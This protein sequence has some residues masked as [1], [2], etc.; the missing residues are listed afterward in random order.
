VAITRAVIPAAGKGTRLYPASRA[1]AKEML[2]LGTKPVVQHVV[3]E[4]V[5]AGIT[6]IVIVTGRKKQAIEDH[7]DADQRWLELANGEDAE[8][9]PWERG[10]KLFYTRQ[11][12]PLGLGDAISKAQPFCEDK[13]FAVA[14]GDA[15]I[16]KKTQGP[17]VVQRLVDAFES[18]GA[19]A[20]VATYQVELEATSRYGILAPAEN[21]PCEGEPFLLAD[22]VEKPGPHTAPSCW[23]VSARYV[24]SPEIF[25]ALE[26]CRDS[27]KPGEELQLTSAL[28]ELIRRGRSVYGV[29]LASDE[30]RLDVGDFVSYGRAFARMLAMHPKH[31]PK[32][33]EY[34]R[35]LVAFEGGQG[36]DPD[37]WGS[38]HCKHHT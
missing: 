37:V 14:L 20:C 22:I 8:I 7:F 11:S 31:G 23:A 25:E 19:A 38:P 1:Q 24:L 6:E 21:Q 28:Q 2:V 9:S 34:L 30:F 36:A 35:K 27:V 26:K 10:V 33:V 29:P 5:A 16:V 17:G 18:L 32:F 3:E 12:E 13:P 4:I 15:V